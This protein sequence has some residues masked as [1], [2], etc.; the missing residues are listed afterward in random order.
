MPFNS[1]LF[2]FFFLPVTLALYHVSGYRL[3]NFTL[4]LASLLFYAWG[5]MVSLPVLLW[6]IVGNYL[7]GLL[8]MRLSSAIWRKALLALGIAVNLV[9]LVHYKYT[10]FLLVNLNLLFPDHHFSFHVPS[11]SHIPLGMS[12]IAFHAISYLVDVFRGRASGQKNPLQLGLYLAFFPKVLSGPIHRYADAASQL[13]FRQVTLDGFSKGVERFII[14]LAKKMLLANA[15]A[16]IADT[17]FQIPAVY[18]SV[19]A[20]WLG[21]VCYTL[22]IY[23]DFS[24]YTDMAIGLGYMFGFRLPENFN[25]PYLAQSVQEFWQRW[26]ITLSQWFR[27]YLYIPLG[28]NRRGN[29]RTYGNLCVVFLLCGLWH[30]ANWTFIV[31]GLMHGLFLVLERWRL[32]AFLARC[33]RLVRHL[34]LLLFIVVSWVFFRAETLNG[35]LGYLG[36]MLGIGTQPQ[37]NPWLLLKMDRQIALVLAL[38]CLFAFP[39]VPFI[40]DFLRRFADTQGNRGELYLNIFRGI[41]VVGFS[42]LF[43]LALMEMASGTYNPFIYFRF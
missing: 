41:K 37:T 39:L 17:I 21:A 13:P 27:D 34:Y 2:L 3:R 18:L 6:I 25:Y 11:Q 22:Q 9:P 15:L 10:G 32:A 23:F 30:G 40:I 16:E 38:S 43:L 29:V 33:P 24:G 12:F 8:L 19:E 35:A 28:G 36:A 20:S 4:L 31:W 1:L 26:H 7:F 5:G 42:C 14:G